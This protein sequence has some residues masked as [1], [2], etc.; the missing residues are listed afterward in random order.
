MK[1]DSL[2]NTNNPSRLHF[3][4]GLRGIAIL[5]VILFHAYSDT[6]NEFLPYHNQYHDF[7]IFK[8][9]NY[10][11]Q[12]FFLISGFVLDGDTGAVEYI[13]VY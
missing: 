7:F 12:L 2:V 8:Y 13:P 9:G 4:D 10:G 6:W 3:L 1:T 11:V 5:L